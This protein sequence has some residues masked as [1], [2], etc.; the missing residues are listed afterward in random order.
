MQ[1]DRREQSDMTSTEERIPREA[2]V[3][4]KRFEEREK[5]EVGKKKI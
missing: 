5:K 2:V 3:R 4:T 1:P